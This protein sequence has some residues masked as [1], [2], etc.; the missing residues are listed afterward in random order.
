MPRAL[1]SVTDKSGIAA[2]A[3]ALTELGYEIVSTGGT[4][5]ALR[6]SGVSVVDVSEVTGF[7]EMLDGRVKTLHPLVHGGLLGDR[8]NASHV[9]Q[10]SEAGIV[11]IDVVCVNLYAFE[12]TVAGPHDLEKAIE[13]ID[14]GGPAM[15][16]ASAKNWAN[17]A[18]VVDPG[19]YGQVID[20][21]NTGTIADIRLKLAAKAFRHTA[22]YDSVISRY[23][24]SAAG[25]EAL[26]ESLTMG[27]RRVQTMRYGENP[28]QTAALYQ[29]PL[30]HGGVARAHQVWGK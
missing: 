7:P 5:K 29:D 17:V 3:R 18:V 11:G 13:S 1:I 12:Q 14:I 8:R 30:T 16:R 15:V 20:A 28:H 22:Y 26:S 24:T 9:A 10:M 6:E 2:F 21:L 4:A 27:Y 25:E 19:D 23:L